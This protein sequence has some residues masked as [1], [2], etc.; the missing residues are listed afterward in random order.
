M[1]RLWPGEVP[2]WER[3]AHERELEETRAERT[4]PWLGLIVVFVAAALTWWPYPGT[5]YWKSDDFLATHYATDFGRAVSDFFHNQY[6]L[7]GAIWF[8]RPLITLSFAVEALLGG[9]ADPTIS[10]ASNVIAHAF[11]AVLV[12]LCALR[13]AT[14]L[15]AMVCG[16]VWALSPAHAGSVLWAVGR[17]DS[18]TTLWALA[19]VWL[20]LRSLDG[21]K[22]SRLLS[23]LACALAFCSKESS[24]VLPGIALVVGFSCAESPGVGARVR[25]ALRVAWPF[26][27]VLAGYLSW[28]FLLF[29]RIGGYGGA[30]HAGPALAGFAASTLRQ[31][32]PLEY[33]GGA[34]FALPQYVWLAGYLP[35]IVALVAIVRARRFGLL[36]TLLVLYVG[37][38]VPLFQL[39]EHSDNLINLRNFYLP[40]VF[41]AA[42]LGA[43][44]WVPGLLAI[45]VWA[46]PLVELRQDYAISSND[47]QERHARLLDMTVELPDVPVFVAGLQ[48][49]NAKGTVLEFDVGVDRLVRP[50]FS[51]HTSA[52]YPLRPLAQSPTTFRLPYGDE[53]AVPLGATLAYHSPRILGQLRQPPH[54]D[55]AVE[56]EG[57]LELS[58]ERL[59]RLGKKREQSGDTSGST[60]LRCPGQAGNAFRLTLFTGRGYVST[61]IPSDDD[62]AFD[63]VFDLLWFRYDTE[64]SD[65]WAQALITPSAIDL[66][67]RFPLLVEVGQIVES[68]AGPVFA[69]E[70]CARDFVWIELDGDY[71]DLMT[72]RPPGE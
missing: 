58:S 22:L 57:S 12:V 54:A 5:V 24:L 19:C 2:P 39:L 3:D 29:D 8:Y 20:I 72:G 47:V 71:A 63:L 41:L 38:C 42:L 59:H 28:R 44:G 52:I 68:V 15:S 62:G 50:P 26:F 14:P 9:G 25:R 7:R 31:L 43:G 53:T 32:N 55:L 51:E 66:S 36:A 21:D 18:H 69:L 40:G 70:S 1:S 56:V 64:S 48:P 34:V 45:A 27:A 6:D 11:S 60:V 13:F 37:S 23:V 67:T 30:F 49:V 17:V 35:A 33:A 10:H 4:V 61:L 16:L 46:L 65:R